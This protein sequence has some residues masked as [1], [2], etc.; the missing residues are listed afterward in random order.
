LLGVALV[1]AGVMG[2]VH[3]RNFMTFGERARV[4]CVFDPDPDKSTSLA[5]ELGA[6]VSKSLEDA[7][8][9]QEVNA[10]AI[11]VPPTL[12]Q[13]VVAKALDR[14]KHVFL[15]KP[16]ATNRAQAQAIVE[17]SRRT[18]RHVMVG[19]VLRFWPGYP[20]VH[21]LVVGGTLGAPLSMS[22]LRM[23]PPP[24][25]VGWLADVEVTGGIAPL[26]L[27]HDFDLMN[28]MFGS[29]ETVQSIALQGEGPGAPH[30][31]VG[32][33]YARGA[34]VVE[35]SVSLPTSHPFSTSISVYCEEA[36]VHYGYEVPPTLGSTQ[37]DANQ[38]SPA[39]QPV[40]SI[41]RSDGKPGE[42]IPISA[43][44]V[45]RPEL[46][47]F[48]SCVERD[49]PIENGT[50]DQAMAALEVALAANLSLS[51]GERIAVESSAIADPG[52]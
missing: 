50:P 8:S 4:A 52:D 31:A 34:G 6:V 14:G 19:H 17:L 28:W 39:S 43:T 15:E 7:L 22:C 51:T 11:A 27:I 24:S 49:E 21:D 46:E 37:R 47:H 44:N 2:S 20:E 18:D 45:W 5:G 35:G 36:S 33:S 23:Q 16:I 42:T 12:H 13:E 26:V 1:G 3:G 25:K 41:Y 48:V 10:V 32:V 29:P 30:V 40:I 38:F 9:H